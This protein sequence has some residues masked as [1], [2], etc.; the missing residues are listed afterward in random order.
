MSPMRNACLSVMLA[1]LLV[2]HSATAVMARGENE[3]WFWENGQRFGW[4]DIPDAQRT[5]LPLPPIT[6]KMSVVER[7]GRLVGRQMVRDRA[8]RVYSTQLEDACIR[9]G[10]RI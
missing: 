10:G 3:V 4:S 8:G 7:C 5:I 1:A 9:N 2:A 6:S